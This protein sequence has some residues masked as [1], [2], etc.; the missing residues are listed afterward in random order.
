MQQQKGRTGYIAAVDKNLAK[1]EKN[2]REQ[3]GRLEFRKRKKCEEEEALSKFSIC[4]K[5]TIRAK[6]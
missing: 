1:S 5:C 6:N 3:E 2:K 4:I